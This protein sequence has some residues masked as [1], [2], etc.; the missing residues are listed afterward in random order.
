MFFNLFIYLF[1][2]DY[3]NRMEIEKREDGKK[4]AG[5]F[6]AGTGK[7][8]GKARLLQHLNTKISIGT[9]VGIIMNK[10]H[11]IFRVFN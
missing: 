4:D 3:E 5:Q 8:G 6:V 9:E 7:V 1:I 11:K 2:V 10:K